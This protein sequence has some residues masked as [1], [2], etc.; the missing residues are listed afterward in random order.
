M[1]DQ[2]GQW[3]F[4]LSVFVRYYP[5]KDNESQ[6]SVDKIFFV[7]VHPIESSQSRR[8]SVSVFTEVER[9]YSVAKREM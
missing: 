6:L 1:V 8:E 2:V 4:E 3:N 7:R 9:V 5:D